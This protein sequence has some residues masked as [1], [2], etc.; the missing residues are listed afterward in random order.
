[1]KTVT[2]SF[3]WQIIKWTV[4]LTHAIFSSKKEKP[5]QTFKSNSE[6]TLNIYK[7]APFY[8]MLKLS[9]SV[10]WNIKQSLSKIS[11]KLENG[12]TNY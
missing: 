10:I 1:M 3:S 11:K 2:L 5:N 12:F 4:T 8:Y 7:L 6:I 9:A